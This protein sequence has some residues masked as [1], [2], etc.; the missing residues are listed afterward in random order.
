MRERESIRLKKLAGEPWPWTKDKI[1]QT[2]S[3]TNVKREH[4]RTSQL[5]IQEFYKP[6]FL[7][8]R[9]QIILN[10]AIARNFGT[11]EFMRE[12]GWQ[13]KFNPTLLKKVARA[14]LQQG[15]KVFTG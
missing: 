6:N 1:L 10:C 11:I 13:N 8:P 14:R 2:Y 5:L 9:E 7:A 4:D 3:F 12:I 15:K